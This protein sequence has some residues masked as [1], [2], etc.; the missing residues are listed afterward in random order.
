MARFPDSIKEMKISDAYKMVLYDLVKHVRDTMKFRWQG[1]PLL[2]RIEFTGYGRKEIVALEIN[3]SQIRVLIGWPFIDEKSFVNGVNESRYDVTE[4]LVPA[5][6]Y[7][8]GTEE[9][10]MA[11]VPLADPDYKQKVIQAIYSGLLK[12][13]QGQVDWRSSEE[14]QNESLAAAMRRVRSRLEMENEDYIKQCKEIIGKVEPH[15]KPPGETASNVERGG[16][17]AKEKRNF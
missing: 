13:A 5:E 4:D 15:T 16:G 7:R 9:F 10:I 14:Y 3:A 6:L 12:M 11:V 17:E 8:K 2:K 1:F